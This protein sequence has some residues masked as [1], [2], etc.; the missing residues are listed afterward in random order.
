[1]HAGIPIALMSPLDFLRHPLSWLRRISDTGATPSGGPNFAYDL[2]V[3]RPID[4]DELRTLDL[5]AWSVAFN[6]AEPV[7]WRTMEAFARKFAPAGFR[8]SAFFPCYGLAEA[9]L[10]V[11]GQHWDG[12]ALRGTERVP[13]TSP[14]AGAAGPGTAARVSC[15]PGLPDQRLEIVDPATLT[16]CPEGVEGEVWLRGPSVTAGY[17]SAPGTGPFGDL[18]GDRYLRTSDLGYVV[19]GGLVVSGRLDGV[20]VHR[21]VNHHAGDVEDA[22]VGGDPALRPVAAAFAV[23]GAAG[24]AGPVIAVVVE[25]RPDAG[26]RDATAAAVRARVLAATGLAVDAVAVAPPGTIPRTSSGKVQRHLCRDRFVAGDLDGFLGA[27]GRAPAGGDV[28]GRAAAALT[29]LIQGVFAVVCEVAECEPDGSLLDLGGDSLRA[30]EIAGV[31]EDALGT[32]VTVE[33]V[34]TALTPEAL[35]GRL[36]DPARCPDGDAR[37]L[38]RRVDELVGEHAT[39]DR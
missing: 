23:D 33:D 25:A 19:D 36:L 27:G 17:W 6:G 9:T 2:C 34:L 3:R 12:S 14:A 39:V 22:A 37:R 35:A 10:L 18:D 11:A 26:D 20:I 30:A 24:D 31:L 8:P 15:G 38:A 32:R 28:D 13:A 4:S 5:S 16:R 29:G 21:G 7:R 1:M